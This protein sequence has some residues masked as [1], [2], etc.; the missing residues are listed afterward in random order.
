MGITPHVYHVIIRKKEVIKFWE[1]K[2]T[3]KKG[4]RGFP[5]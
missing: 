2:I 3:R 5:N 4:K 1:E